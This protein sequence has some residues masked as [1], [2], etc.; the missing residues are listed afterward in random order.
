[1]VFKLFIPSLLHLLVDFFSIYLLLSFKLDQNI[2]LI[3]IVLYD[4]LAFM[5]QPLIGAIIEK[6]KNL[7]KIMTISLILIIASLFI[8]VYYL[9]I[10]LCAIGNAL[11]HVS[12][13]KLVL[14]KSQKSAPL[15]VFISFGAL[16]VGFASLYGTKELFTLL[17]PILLILLLVN[18][19]MDYSDINYTYNKLEN[20]Q[21]LYIFPT[22]LITFGVILRGFF[23]F[24]CD[25]SS[26]ITLNNGSLISVIIVFFAK[27]IGGFLIDK[28]KM[29]P[30]IIL[31]MILSLFGTIF[32]YN[33][34]TYLLGVF[35]V[36]LL[37]ALT[38]ELIR[39]FLPNNRA[40][41]FGLL[42]SGLAFGSLCGM[43][44]ISNMKYNYLINV[45]LIILNTLTLLIALFCYKK[46]KGILL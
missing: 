12:A 33:Y 38:L 46:K 31:S 32:S 30:V 23:G 19:I 8:N 27:F 14:D 13:G 9:A 26:L 34:Y 22:I 45:V 29:L 1:M 15:G 11:F 40:F 4:S 10:P 7:N 16:G 24:Y 20:N 28:V 2:A 21:K 6:K 43:F 5:S 41:G 44:L 17:F 35:G 39:R 18:S 37:M 36:N 25:K 42:A 3:L